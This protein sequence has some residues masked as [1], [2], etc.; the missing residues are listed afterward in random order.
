[1]IL[2]VAIPHEHVTWFATKLYAI[3]VKETDLKTP[4]K[5]SKTTNAAMKENIQS[6][7]KGWGKYA[8]MYVKAALL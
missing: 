3:P 4:T 1:M 6:S 8:D 5:G 2:G 7:L